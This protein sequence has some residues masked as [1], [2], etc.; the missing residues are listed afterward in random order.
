MTLI[1][2]VIWDVQRLRVLSE[3]FQWMAEIMG[4]R[5]IP[6]PPLPTLLPT[7]F[8][9]SLTQ[10]HLCLKRLST[11]PSFNNGENQGTLA[12]LQAPFPAPMPSAQRFFRHSVLKVYCKIRVLLRKTEDWWGSHRPLLW[13]HRDTVGE[14]PEGQDGWVG[15]WKTDR[16]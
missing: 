7:H 11:P 13:G 10:V 5:R 12:G 16:L 6:H 15:D 1:A 9:L 3:M 4:G 2:A 14:C 8:P